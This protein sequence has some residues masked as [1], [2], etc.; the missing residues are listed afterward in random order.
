M[1]R[2]FYDPG[3]ALMGVSAGMQFLGGRQQAAQQR[4]AGE[5]AAINAEVQGEQQQFAAERRA[6]DLELTARTAAIS[7]QREL[8]DARKQHS[9]ELART[10]AALA[11][12]GADLGSGTPLAL[13]ASQAAEF[14]LQRTR[15]EQDALITQ[16]TL[17]ARAANERD[18]GEYLAGASGIRAGNERA[19]GA[20][21]ARSSMLTGI[22]NAAGTL[23]PM[24]L[25]SF[26]GGGDT[27]A[28][29][30]ADPGV[31]GVPGGFTGRGA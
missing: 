7:T 29:A 16:R 3:T 15:V 25:G 28:Q 27:A 26:G 13:Q 11:A 12:Q 24:A 1:A 20:A 9:R 6:E 4:A 10:R 30:A 8:R 21:A 2:I 14:A 19:F 17:A 23:A 31:M 18:I 22:V 5:A